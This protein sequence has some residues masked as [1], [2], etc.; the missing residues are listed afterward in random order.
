MNEVI[1][2]IIPTYN[3]ANLIIKTLESIKNQSYSY[4][5]CIIIDDGS[6][7]NSIDILKIFCK[8]DN[9]FKVLLRPNDTIKGAATCRNIGLFKAEGD[10]VIFLDSDDELLKDCLLNRVLKFNEFR[11]ESFLVFPMGINNGNTVFKKD[12]EY[13]QSYLLEFLKYKLPWSIMCPIWKR[14]FLIKLNGFKEGYPRLNDP[15]LM[16][17]ALLYPDVKFKVFNDV[18]YDTIYYPSVGN[19]AL[20]ADKYFESLKLFIPDIC[21][22][23]ELRKKNHLKHYLSGYFKVWFKDFMFPSGR[24]LLNQNKTLIIL[25][26]KQGVNSFIKSIWL[27]LLFGVFLIFFKIE[28]TTKE[29]IINIT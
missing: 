18:D 21:N 24:N 13:R 22:E 6:T 2:I 12:I 25:F 3:R 8:E 19:W 17:R 26:Y 9:R 16:L 1:S 10:Y 7:D 28:R 29:K 23:L 27:A 20:M 4:W 5:E 11:N 15:E 14:E